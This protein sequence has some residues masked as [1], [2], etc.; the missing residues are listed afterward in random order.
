MAAAA[1][2]TTALFPSRVA[3]PPRRNP[4][5]PPRIC[6]FSSSRKLNFNYRGYPCLRPKT[7]GKVICG[8]IEVV[9]GV[10]DE[11]CELVNGA[12]LIIG[13][14]DDSIHAYLLKAVKNNN[15]TGVLLLSDIFGFEDSSTRDFA[16][17]VACNG[18]N[19]LVPDLFRGNPW[20]KSRPMAELE[21]WL[22]TQTLER[23]A[24]DI[25]TC[26]KW[27]MD[28]FAA[29]GISK[30]LGIIGFCFGGGRLI[31]ALA[32]DYDCEYFGTGVCFYGTSVDPSLGSR[33]KAPVLFIA[34][35][36]DPLCPLSVLEEIEKKIEGSRLAIYLGRKH[37]FAH[38]PDSQEEDAD[39]EDAFTAMRNWLHDALLVNDDSVL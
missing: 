35:D 9:D 33:I 39:A 11:A 12:D 24:K 29:A 31:E 13:E 14:G 4:R 20:K 22:A 37:G 6:N 23:V 21:Q 36:N 18:Y 38:R 34:G 28:E 30:K 16:Y 32:R 25:D 19:V 15:G 1:A 5:H 27:L 3:A 17:R 10:D 8:Q 26:A 7:S 2:A